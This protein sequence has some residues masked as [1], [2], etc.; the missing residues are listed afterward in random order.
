MK[1]WKREKGLVWHLVGGLI[2]TA[3][4]F[5][6][7][8]VFG[9]WDDSKPATVINTLMLSSQFMPLISTFIAI[10]M[11]SDVGLVEPYGVRVFRHAQV[12]VGRR[13]IASLIFG[14]L[15]IAP[16][17]CAWVITEHILPALGISAP[18]LSIPWIVVMAL[19]LGLWP[20]GASRIAAML[21]YPDHRR[22]ARGTVNMSGKQR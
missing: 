3:V 5:P 7:G 18:F 14:L 11:L 9:D 22:L 21:V 6:I 17:V 15:L 13:L 4:L 19:V 12:G 2:V 8:L 20:Y 16:A 1:W 10:C